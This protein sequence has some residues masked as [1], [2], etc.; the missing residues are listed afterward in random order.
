[1]HHGYYPGGVPRTDH[2]QAQVD[3]V[4]KSLEWAGVEGPVTR[5][6]DV[7]C[8]IGGSSRHMARKF[9]CGA[10][11]ITLSPV[12]AARANVLTTEAGL[13]DVNFLVG[14]A[15]DQ[16]FD[17]GEFDLVYSMESG[18]HMPDKTQFVGELTRVCAPGG[19]ILVV[20]WC[21]RVLKDGETCLP[22]DEQFLLDR[23]CDAYYLPAWCSVAD[24]ARIAADAGLVDVRT[25]DWSKEVH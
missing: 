19:R 8:G 15:L 9:G 16:P 13:G 10:R 21:H 3:M 14:D 17:D 1:M 24:Y 2:A 25:A 20:T 7:G 4:D 22:A 18:E 5:V 6:V 11:G 12:Q 23:I